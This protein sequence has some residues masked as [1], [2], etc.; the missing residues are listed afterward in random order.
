MQCQARL[1]SGLNKGNRCSSKA[2]DGN[3][4]CGRHKKNEQSGGKKEMIYLV[5]VGGEDKARIK[6]A[7]STEYAAFKY[8]IEEIQDMSRDLGGISGIYTPK[9]ANKKE[10]D[11]MLKS[12]RGRK[13]L[14]N[15]PILQDERYYID[16]VEIDRSYYDGAVYSR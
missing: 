15:A 8:I 9:Y 14:P 13:V 16:Y 6:R 4:F 10:I 5:T 2:L 1:V 7:L 3:S 12:I 11:L